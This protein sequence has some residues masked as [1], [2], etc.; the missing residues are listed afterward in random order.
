M[1]KA[2]NKPQIHE[3]ATQTET[4]W[5]WKL[6]NRESFAGAAKRNLQHRPHRAA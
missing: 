6:Q 3:R 2:P 4:L 5:M 1:A